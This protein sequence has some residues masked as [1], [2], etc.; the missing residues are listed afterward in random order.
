MKTKDLSFTVIGAFGIFLGSTLKVYLDYQRLPE[1]YAG[2]PRPWFFYGPL[3]ILGLFLAVTA[4]CLALYFLRKK[5]HTGGNEQKH[6][7]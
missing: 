4:V 6:G 1:L 7:D 2:R 5:L 3:Q